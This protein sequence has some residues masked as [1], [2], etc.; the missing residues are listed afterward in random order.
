MGG[1][2]AGRIIAAMA[3]NQIGGD[4]AMVKHI[5]DSMSVEISV[6]LP[7]KPIAANLVL[8]SFPRPA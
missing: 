4:E 8:S 2:Y 1:I 5:R 6:I 3:D 7:K